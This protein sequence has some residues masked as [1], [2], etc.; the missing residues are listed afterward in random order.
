MSI[1]NTSAS[2]AGA[3]NEIRNRKKKSTVGWLPLSQGPLIVRRIN[4]KIN[5]SQERAHRIAF[6][7]CSTTPNLRNYVEPY[8]RVM[9]PY[10]I[11]NHTISYVF[12]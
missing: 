9:N 11:V 2:A 5:E 6:D 7:A 1:S 10:F 12:K 3:G 4:T 8:C